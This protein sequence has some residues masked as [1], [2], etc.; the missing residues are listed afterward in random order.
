MGHDVAAPAASGTVAPLPTSTDTVQKRKEAMAGGTF[1]VDI[2]AH[3]G[4]QGLAHGNFLEKIFQGMFGGS[5]VLGQGGIG[6]TGGPSGGSGGGFGQL[7]LFAPLAGAAKGLGLLSKIKYLLPI[8]GEGG[9]VL[10]LFAAASYIETKMPWYDPKKTPHINPN[11]PLSPWTAWYSP[12]P[13]EHKP[14]PSSAPGSMIPTFGYAG[15]GKNWAQKLFG[16]S[17]IY[18]H[19]A[20]PGGSYEHGVDISGN[21]GD[22]VKL[23]AAGRYVPEYSTPYQ[24]VFDVC[25][26]RFESYTHIDPA[27]NLPKGLIPAG[28]VIANISG[29]YGRDL[30]FENGLNQIIT[31][32]SSKPHLEFGVYKSAKDAGWFTNDLKPIPYLE[33]SPSM[34]LGGG[35]Q[36]PGKLLPL[37]LSASAKTGIPASVLAAMAYQES[38]FGKTP[39]CPY[40]MGGGYGVGLMH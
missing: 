27:T 21:T 9:L 1:A 11:D 22:P 3:L 28:T 25:G 7:P 39:G 40:Q 18:A 10:G 26:G 24:S 5:F 15:G 4:A 12:P 23:A 14:P 30:K 6:T 13:F 32:Q 33:N 8:I 31:Y 2:L 16:G 35:I 29:V 37:F 17:V 34:T 36:V 20:H 19:G 38:K